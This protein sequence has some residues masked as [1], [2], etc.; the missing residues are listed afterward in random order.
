MPVPGSGNVSSSGFP[1]YPPSSQY[2]GSNVYP[3]YPP[4]ASGGFPYPSSY[5]SYAGTTPSY[6]PQ[7]YSGPYPPYPPVTQP[8]YNYYLF[9]AQSIYNIHFSLN[10]YV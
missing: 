9:L 1:P 7:S 8:V 5:G 3:P 2:S 10:Y 6:P 4:T